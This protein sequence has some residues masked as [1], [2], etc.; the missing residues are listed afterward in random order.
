MLNALLRIIAIALCSLEFRN[1]SM[2]AKNGIVRR[3]LYLNRSLSTLDVVL[4]NKR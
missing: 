4:D 2:R 3:K 1:W